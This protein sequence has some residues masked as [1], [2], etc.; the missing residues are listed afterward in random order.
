[1]FVVQ[2]NEMPTN[3]ALLTSKD[4]FLPAVW[5]WICFKLKSE[6]LSHL[7]N[8]GTFCICWIW[9]GEIRTKI[10]EI[11]WNNFK[12]I[13]LWNRRCS[14]HRLVDFWKMFGFYPIFF[15]SQKLSLE[16]AI[17]SLGTNLQLLLWKIMYQK[18]KYWY[19]QCTYIFSNA[20]FRYQFNEAAIIIRP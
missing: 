11:S 10:L 3:S 2:L 1:M 18:R 5:C 7:E 13:F 17:S 8:N 6:L 15:F 16:E 19:V 12:L 9:F 20:K 4:K 14:L